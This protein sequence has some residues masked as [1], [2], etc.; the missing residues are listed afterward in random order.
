MIV[1]ILLVMYVVQ[2][3]YNILLMSMSL[4]CIVCIILV[5][6]T[7]QSKVS[8]DIYFSRASDFFSRL[9]GRSDPWSKKWWA[10]F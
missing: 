8:V 4:P 5:E 6:I 10:I 2:Y 7:D 3:N 9:V 1:T